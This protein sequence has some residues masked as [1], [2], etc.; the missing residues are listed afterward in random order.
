MVNTIFIQVAVFKLKIRK[1]EVAPV[2]KVLTCD[3]SELLLRLSGV[4]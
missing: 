3:C 1:N 2:L 4:P